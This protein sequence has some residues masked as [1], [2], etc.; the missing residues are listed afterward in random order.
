MTTDPAPTPH[1]LPRL[2]ADLEIIRERGERSGHAPGLIYDPLRHRFIRIDRASL[3]LMAIM[4]FCVDEAA[5]REEA[6]K[7]LGRDINDNTVSQFIEFL[8][9]ADLTQPTSGDR[10]R[11]FEKERNTKKQ[12]LL[13]RIVHGYLFFKLPLFRPQRFLDATL[14]IA[15]LFMTRT[16]GLI[17]A[18][19][20]LAGLYLVSRQ[21]DAFTTTFQH[22]FSF[23]GILTFALVL[24]VVKALHEL[25][26]AYTAANYGCRVSSLGVAFMFLMPLLYTDVTDTWRIA[27]RRRRLIVDAA[28]IIVELAI[29]CVATLLWVFLPES[30]AKS[31]VFAIATISWIM[32]LG[33]NLN[34][35]MRFD[36]YYILS[37][38][39]GVENLQPRAFA[40][41]RWHLR[42]ALFNLRAPCPEPELYPRRMTFITYAWATWVYRFFLFLGIALLIYALSFKLLGV[43]LFVLEVVILIIAPVAAE[44]REWFKMRQT[45][46]KQTRTAMTLAVLCLVVAL[47]AVPWSTRV[48]V[49]ARMSASHAEQVFPAMPA[50]I[51]AVHVSQGDR[52]SHGDTLIEFEAPE[53]D[54]KLKLVQLQLTALRLRLARRAADDLDRAQSLVLERENLSLTTKADG[55]RGLR[56]KLTV[57]APASGIVT[58][59]AP[60][61][62]PGRWMAATQ[63]I[64]RIN[65]ST[66]VE[67]RGYIDQADVERIKPDASGTFIPDIPEL[68]SVPVQVTSV[69][70]AGATKLQYPE[71][72]SVHGGPVATREGTQGELVP[73][74]AQYLIVMKAAADNVVL[75]QTVRGVVHITGEPES[76]FA[77]LWRR[78]LAVLVRES[79]I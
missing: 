17:V 31:V 61:L 29:A 7:R 49:A 44:L 64:A 14:P 74:T 2:R 23:E 47:I 22:A 11:A 72:A 67:V 59:V 19:S 12:A 77:R 13:T 38:I 57:T 40:L 4:P 25:G 66:G 30:P 68:A 78:A 28:G 39:L 63:R 73:V 33:F 16:A 50:R 51:Q 6:R 43:A 18:L 60:N 26:H 71:L 55:L 24:G 46:V 21:W 5:L 37:D 8:N 62:H 3:D 69:M 10:W 1:A 48:T 75:P 76:I 27:S 53:L 54:A 65:P 36:G 15:R 58:D 35:F 79:G 56:K 45:I 52:V 42:E 70:R 20:G 9:R 41:A 34:P 32:S